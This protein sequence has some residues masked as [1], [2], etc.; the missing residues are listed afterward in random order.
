[1]EVG[2]VV[3]WWGL[4]QILL[5]LGWPLAATLLPDTPDRGA[6]LAIP[7]ALV[8][9]GFPVFWIGHA[10][11]S[12]VTYLTGFAVLLVV[13]GLTVR[14]RDFRFDSRRYVEIAS[15]FT[16][17]FL[18]MVIIRAAAAGIYPAGGEKFLDYGLLKSILRSD[19][20]PPADMWFA[21]KRMIYYYG[22]HLLTA[23]LAKLSATSG[24]FAY[25]L[26]LSGFY[27]MEVTAVYGLASAI[28]SSRGISRV[29]AGLFGA[30][31]FGF[32]SNLL[33]P[34]RVA[35]NLLPQFVIEDIAVYLDDF[36]SGVY[37]LKPGEVT[38]TPGTFSYWTASRV[39]PKTINEFPLFSYRNGDLHAHMMSMA[40]TLL[41]IGILYGYYRTP[42][43]QRR[44]RLSLLFGAVPLVVGMQIFINTWSIPTMLGLTALSV[45][46]APAS[47]LTLVPDSYRF[48]SD[49][50][51]SQP[52]T[53]R[54]SLTVDEGL[55]IALGVVVA[56]VVG[57]IAVGLAFPFVFG[58]LAAG[59][60]SRHVAFFPE[61]SPLG[62]FL[63]VH[64]AFL[65]VFALYLGSNILRERS[66]L[67]GAVLI[68]VALFAIAATVGF[69]GLVLVAPLV[70]VGWIL[71]R[72]GRLSFDGVLLVAGAG[73]VVL[74]E[75]VYLAD[76][77]GPGRFNTVFKTSTQIWTIWAPVTG[78][79]L[80]SFIRRTNSI[81]S[82]STAKRQTIGSVF[83]A[84]LFIMLSFYGVFTV[85]NHLDGPTE[86]TLD[87]MEY[88]HE[89]HPKQAAAIE[90]LDDHPG[91]PFLVSAPGWKVYSWQNPASSLTGIPTVAG[92]AHEAIYRGGDTYR[93]RVRD[94]E[95]LFNTTEAR[96]RAVL[97][98][99]YDVE[100][101]YVGPIERNR[102]DVQDYGT[103]PGIHVVY[104][105]D[106]VTIYRVHRHELVRR[107]N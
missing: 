17:A 107:N 44:R 90:W 21:G 104:R 27:A 47:P 60:G 106:A 11:L 92:W 72:R 88:A 8:V 57:T 23:T 37:V 66:H 100:F 91:Q 55:R 79:A 40:F 30:F 82:I 7:T 93:R 34:A 95:I 85:H 29:W 24:R 2:R 105:N 3:V 6:S 51:H 76:N 69:V 87:G 101:I 15:V 62:P 75:F 52:T 9:I 28:A 63:L 71:V 22:G 45:A 25:A 67:A 80:A 77:A 96:S 39:I 59:A 73:L 36:A 33:T 70:V 99:K 81:G 10:V 86:Y 98:R 31:V 50:S 12:F 74:V 53:G 32:A 5:L 49:R 65:L 83:V 26:A 54:L 97:L 64:G 19:Y 94:V 38:V 48:V 68:T 102:Y 56:V 18:F 20:L 1:M 42:A 46:A 84:V 103:E 61:R 35:A 16:V 58:T 78:V 89:T 43:E 4:Y 41:L 14:Y 13:S